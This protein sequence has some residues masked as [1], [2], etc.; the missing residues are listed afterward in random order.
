MGYLDIIIIAILLIGIARGWKTGFIR[1]ASNLAGLVL[2]FV[3]AVIFMDSLG[4]V[5]EER[6]M[7]YPGLGTILAF[8]GIF[9][10]VKVAT[11]YFSRSAKDLI[12]AMHL[13][14]VDSLAGGLIGAFKAGIILSL[15]FVSISYFRIP[16]DTAVEESRL[17]QP[18]YEI[19]P[20][21]WS[22]LVG[23]SSALEDIKSRVDS[24]SEKREAT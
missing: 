15:V 21:A 22:F 8:L 10:V 13:G 23:H 6:I 2:A 5:I 7:D 20:Q 14:S 16:D 11:A 12:E 18:V 3:L 1:Q 19:V 4:L 24:R 17:Y 9:V